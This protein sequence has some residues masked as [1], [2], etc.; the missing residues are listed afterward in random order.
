MIK[1]IIKI[2]L[3]KQHNDAL[4]KLFQLEERLINKRELMVETS[5]YI[6]LLRKNFQQPK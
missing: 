5:K 2:S 4:Q 3:K 1:N 6:E